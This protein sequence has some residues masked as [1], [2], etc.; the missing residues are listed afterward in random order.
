[1]HV[2]RF[3]DKVSD[4]AENDTNP[5]ETSTA[6]MSL[7]H[8]SSGVGHHVINAFAAIVSH[9]DIL[10]L[11]LANRTTVDRD[12]LISTIIRASLDASEVA[13]R[14]IAYSRKETNVGLE[15]LDFRR[16]I[17]DYAESKKKNEATLA[18]GSTVQIFAETDEVPT[19]S[20]NATHLREMLDRL[21]ANAIEASNP[22]DSPS[23]DLRLSVDQR[24]WVVLEVSDQGVGMD[25]ETLQ[26]ATEPFFSTK[27]GHVGVGLTVAHGIWRRHRGT[28]SITSIPGSGTTIRLCVDPSGGLASLRSGSRN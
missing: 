28:L 21:V 26:R 19:I 10:R 14:L 16:I 6:S 4:M 9:A 15:P 13:R 7:G 22:E 11:T 3:Y 27:A 17:E 8:L 24:G 2:E 18:L 25:A 23:I 12:A 5:Q 1:M 20:G